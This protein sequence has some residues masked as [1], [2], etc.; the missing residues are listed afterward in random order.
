MSPAY[1]T[2]T[3]DTDAI[4]K[5]I[6]DGSRCGKGCVSSSITPAIVFFPPGKYRV[7]KPIVPYYYTSLVGDYNSKPTLIADANFIGTA[8]IDADPHI[9]G[10]SNP[11]GSGINWWTNQN[12]FFRSVRNFAIDVT[13]MPPDR[14]GTGIHW[15]VGQATSLIN[16]DFKMSSAAGT[17]HQGIFMENGSGGFMS[18][19]T[20]DGGA[21]G[22]WLSNQ[23]FTIRNVKITNAVSAIYQLWNWGFT[24]QNIQIS[25]CQVGFDLNTG[26]LTLDTQTTGGVL[27]VDAKISNTGIGIKMSTTQPNSLAGSVVLDNVAFSGI[28]KANI[29]D[30]S[31]IVL[32][33]SAATVP[34]WFQGNLYLGSAKR[35]LR[36]SYTPS[37]S[38][39]AS[40]VDS[41][42][43][44]FSKSRP[45]Y[46]DYQDNRLGAKGDGVTDDTVAINTFLQKYSGCAIL[47]FEAGTYL[48]TD[49]IFVPPNTIIVG[50]MY[51]VIMATGPKFADQNNPRPVIRVGNPGDIGDVE[52]SDMV[53]TTTGGSAG[54]IGI[55]WNIK[56]STQ[57]SAGLW[58]VHI[59]LGGTKGTNI[60]SANCPTTSTDASKCASAFLGLH[61]T[62]TGSGYF[63]VGSH[64]IMIHHDLDDPNQTQLNVFSGRGVLVESARGP[65]WLV[66]TAS[67]HHASTLYGL[68]HSLTA[69]IQ[70]IY[71]YA[72]N[73]AQNVYAGLIQTETPYFQ[74]TPKPPVPFAINPTYGDPVDS[75]LDAWGL[76]ITNSY[77]IYIY[78]AGLYS[79]FQACKLSRNCQ[80]LMVLVDQQSSGIYLYQLTTVGSTSM[81]TYP[82]VS[83][84]NQ[85]D[86]INGFASTL[87]LWEA[88]SVQPP[89]VGGLSLLLI[90][91]WENLDRSHGG[92]S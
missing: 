54:A 66:G 39:P 80:D 46:P 34:H 55:E 61:I 45:Q 33:A 6:S 73:N 23:Q 44:F 83:L 26:G 9:D 69:P 70:V 17:K 56:E 5:A 90:E 10:V 18:D 79:F 35:Y 62:Q 25:N 2:I 42:G 3:D 78:G 43:A 86:N 52:I 59:R 65:V 7:T 84:A 67:E 40:L 75:K 4:N 20:F 72:F 85:A 32:A 51:S 89:Q 81:I 37:G 57:G 38:R 64:V 47:L 16:I 68:Y 22:M 82:N 91:S 11:D 29:Q 77:N 28:S 19:L 60:N 41:S 71:Q 88:P 12:N 24:W 31:G 1:L 14:Y 30:S 50:D 48:V 27:I 63:E 76:I 87:S 36:G 74:P 53:I 13:R 49:T 8:V 21:F 92:R 58:D 15:Q